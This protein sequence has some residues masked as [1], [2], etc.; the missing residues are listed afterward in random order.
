MR[1]FSNVWRKN[2]GKGKYQGIFQKNLPPYSL[3]LH[4]ASP[5]ILD[6][7][8]ELISIP[9]TPPNLIEPQTGCRFKERC[10]FRTEHCLSQEP[11][12]TPVDD[13]GHLIACHNPERV[14][15]FREN[16]HHKETWDIV[17]ERIEKGKEEGSH[18]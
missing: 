16:S 17:R 3:G 18:E 9:S 4:N 5:S 6:I 1:L 14:E 11:A 10:P 12:L 2:Y 7:G 15:E 13:N 8:K